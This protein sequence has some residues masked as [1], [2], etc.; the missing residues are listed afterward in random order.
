MRG[1]WPQNFHCSVGIIHNDVFVKY[2]EP[3]PRR[4]NNVGGETSRPRQ[5]NRWLCFILGEVETPSFRHD[6][7]NW[8]AVQLAAT[9][10]TI[11][12]SLLLAAE[13]W[14]QTHGMCL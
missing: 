11:V 8:W 2:S 10:G 13:M 1:L 6:I 3:R 5:R 12:S 9:Q 7:A 4:K 14:P